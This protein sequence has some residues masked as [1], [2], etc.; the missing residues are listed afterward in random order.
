MLGT[1]CTFIQFAENKHKPLSSLIFGLDKP[2]PAKAK[3]A[4]HNLAHG[5]LAQWLEQRNHNPLV[6]GSNP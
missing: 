2:C 1:Q 4:S 6:R 3:C 5:E